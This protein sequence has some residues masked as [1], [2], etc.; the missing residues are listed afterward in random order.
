MSVY[1]TISKPTTI[2]AI[3][4]T[5]KTVTIP[6]AP[7]IAGLVFR[8]YQGEAD[9]PVMAAV[10]NGS[11]EADGIEWTV[12]AKDIARSYRHLVN[13]DPYRDM[14]FV[15][16]GGQAIGYSRVWWQQELKGT[17]CYQQFAQLLPEWR[18]AGIRKSM[19]RHNERRLREI[20]AGHTVDGLRT[21]QAWAADTETHWESLLKDEGYEAARYSFEMVRPDLENIPERPLP[22]GLEVRPVQPEQVDTIFD[23]AEEAFQDHWGETEWS[24]EERAEWRESPTFQPHLWQVAWD[25]DE[26]AGAVMNFINEE[27]NEEYER[28]RGYTEGIWV[29]RP[30]R[31][32]GLAKALIARSFYVHK[33]LDM[34]EAALGVDALN[35]N[36]ALQLY[37]S[38]GFQEVK[39]HTTYRKPLE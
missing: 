18:G 16:V 7:A 36:G 27:E 15:E 26:V 8:R 28:K 20:A 5:T 38:M 22:E 14:L 12:S 9:S 11:K 1:Q 23:G 4:Q 30:W 2:Q 17:R 19:V 25:G 29:R 24:E 39:R 13:C 21:F 31:R 35:P 32:Q 6:D 10:I 33:A 34:T 3:R 37:R